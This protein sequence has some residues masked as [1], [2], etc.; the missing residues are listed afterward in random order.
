M[1]VLR[2]GSAGRSTTR[3]GEAR[4]GTVRRGVAGNKISRE[5]K[6]QYKKKS[7]ARLPVPA[8]TIGEEL[9]KIEADK[10]TLVPH[11]VVKSARPKK[12][13][14]HS[15]FEWDDAAAAQKHRI[16]QARY[17]IRS[18]VVVYEDNGDEDKDPKTIR[19]F[20]STS[21][22]NGDDRAYESIARVMSDDEKRKRLLTQA[23]G[24]L[25]AWKNRYQG[26]KEF[27]EVYD[28]IEHVD[29][30]KSRPK[31]APAATASATA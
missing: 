8:Q 18:V 21:S 31:R 19:A 22:E 25:R 1:G 5:K 23:L 13:P 11:D 17:L 9:E 30:K 7:G 12:S 15:C 3:F 29:K 27:A 4:T 2:S 24:E 6:M 16:D 14:L 28:A 10:G 26:F 20:V